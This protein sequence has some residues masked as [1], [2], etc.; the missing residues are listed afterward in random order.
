MNKKL[1][2]IAR[3]WSIPIIIYSLVMLIGNLVS[4]ITTGTADPYAVEDYPFIENIPPIFLLIAAV[5]LAISWRYKRTGAIITSFFCFATIP[6]LLGHWPFWEKSINF[7]PYILMLVV[8][9]PGILFWIAS[10]KGKNS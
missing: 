5:G 2:L 1:S 8:L 4:L 6:I 9:T 7:M 10:G 3:I